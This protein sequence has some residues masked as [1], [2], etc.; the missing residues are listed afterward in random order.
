MRDGMNCPYSV[1]CEWNLEYASFACA[2]K[3]SFWMSSSPPQSIFSVPSCVFGN[4]K[5]LL[6]PEAE[7]LDSKGCSTINDYA[8]DV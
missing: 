3:R 5:L 7:L 8:R 4:R 6:R 2:Q 1:T